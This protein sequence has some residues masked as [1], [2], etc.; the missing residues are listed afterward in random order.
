MGL[1]ETGVKAVSGQ[2]PKM[3]TPRVHAVI[4]YAIA[5][6]FFIAGVLLWRRNRRAAVASIACGV[7]EIATAALTDYPGGLK[8]VIS[9][10]THERLDGGLASVVGAMP[11]AMNFANEPEAKLFRAQGIAIAAVTGLTAFEHEW[12]RSWRDVA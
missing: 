1:V 3:I 11:I 12:I 10:S 8:P 6:S 5:G 2:M 4:D 9:F 7:A